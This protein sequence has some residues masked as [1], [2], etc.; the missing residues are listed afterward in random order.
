M[1]LESLPDR[2]VCWWT[3]TILGLVNGRSDTQSTSTVRRL[4]TVGLNSREDN[5]GDD[6]YGETVPKV[7][8]DLVSFEGLTD[9]LAGLPFLFLFNRDASV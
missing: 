7:L 9:V 2:W 6:P 5:A 8:A 3:R 1:D 4:F